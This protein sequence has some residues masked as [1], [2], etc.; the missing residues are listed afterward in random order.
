VRIGW[1][2]EDFLFFHSTAEAQAYAHWLYLA[3]GKRRGPKSE[4][5]WPIWADPL[6]C[7]E[8]RSLLALLDI[9]RETPNS[10]ITRGRGIQ[11]IFRATRVRIGQGASAKF[12]HVFS[13]WLFYVITIW[14]Q[15]PACLGDNIVQAV[16]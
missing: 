16:S 6:G 2:L 1:R 7:D 11:E 12:R 3:M 15:P 14:S 5:T 4:F 10:E 8:V 13:R 9:P